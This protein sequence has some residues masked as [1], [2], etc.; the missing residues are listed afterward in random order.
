MREMTDNDVRVREELRKA[1]AVGLHVFLSLE[2]IMNKEETAKLK[3]AVLDLTHKYI[4]T[5][6]PKEGN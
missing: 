6:P 2:P 1:V 3:G 4:G 5:E